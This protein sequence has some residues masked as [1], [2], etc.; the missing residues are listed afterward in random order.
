VKKKDLLWLLAYPVYQTIGTM[1]HEGSHA[2]AAMA[3]GVKVTEFVFWPNFD[4]GT[5]Q[6]GYVRWESSPTW[7][8]TAAPY[9]CDLLIFFVAILIILEAKPKPRWLWLNILIIG[10]LSPFLNSA[11]SYFGGVAGSYNDTGKLLGVLDPVAVHLYFALTLLFY[12]WGLYHCY[13]R[14]KTWHPE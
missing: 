6:W 8:A 10:M 1:R 9:F 3:E 5:F 7:F 12:A 11:Y 13:F 2:L 14:K 4:L